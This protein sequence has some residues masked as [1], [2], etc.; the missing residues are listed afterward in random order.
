MSQ[1]DTAVI[2]AAG[3]GTRL[4]ALG[5]ET[6]KGFLRMG[7]RTL[8][9]MSI[10]HLRSVG[11]RRV[12]VVTGHLAAFYEELA[13]HSGGLVTTVHNERFAETGSLASLCL[14]GALAAASFLLLESDL[15]YE[16]RALRVLL[17]LPSDSAVLL[18]GRT[19]SGDEVYVEVDAGGHLVAM[20]KVRASLTGHVAGELVGISKIASSLFTVVKR[21]AETLPGASALAD[22]ESGLCAASRLRPVRC[23]LVPNLLW[24]EIDDAAQLARARDH[25]YPAL[26]SLAARQENMGGRRLRQ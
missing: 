12:V 23:H 24:S 26:Q 20:S 16:P 19:G 13:G 2:L 4:G 1:L 25:I 14:G 8:V 7:G 9:E 11:I 15:I 6:P 18:S 3:R 17:D 5:T 21:E 10:E 22:Y